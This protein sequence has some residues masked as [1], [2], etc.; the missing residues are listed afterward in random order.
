MN[1]RYRPQLGLALLIGLTRC[2]STPEGTGTAPRSPTAPSEPTA[3]PTIQDVM[4][5]ED[6]APLEPGIY[7]IDPDTDPSTSLRVEYEVP[8]SGWSMWTGAAKFGEYG[9]VGLSIAI[10][11]NLVRHG[12]NDH[13]R[14]D[15]PVGPSVNDLAAALADLPP[16]E[17]T[18]PPKD[19]T[20]NGYRGKHLELTVPDLPVEGEAGDLLFTECV[21]ENLKSWVA[22]RGGAF[23]G[24]TAPG[25][26]EEF[27]IFDAEGTRLVIAAERSPGSPPEDLA[28]LR[29][30]LDSIQIEP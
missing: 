6:F 14:A 7:F 24:Y 27:W 20:I 30:I 19:V 17:V 1:S 16:F 15:P 3:S 5:L 12:C 23:Y 4:K 13:R 10:V 18:S 28:E 26:S 25:Y 9:H 29:T 22:R 8:V 21:D 2:A 11:T